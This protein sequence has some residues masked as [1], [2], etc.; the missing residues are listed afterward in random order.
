MLIVLGVL[1]TAFSLSRWFWF[2][3]LTLFLGGAALISVFAMISSLVQMITSD[4]MR[5]RVMS[6]YNLA[7][8]GGM[9]IGSL[10]TGAL[11]PVHT[12]PIVVACNGVL[13]I[14]LGV[15][16]LFGHRRV[17]AL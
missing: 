12:A 9:P 2:S 16:F 13:L 11:I 10:A 1:M 4:A 14:G 17:A 7:F 15:Y 8:R 3:C 6:V 5:G